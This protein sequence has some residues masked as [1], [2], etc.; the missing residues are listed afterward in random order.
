VRG[1]L[2]APAALSPEVDGWALEP[3]WMLWTIEKSLA[4]AGNRT[5]A[6]QTVT[7]SYID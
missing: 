5:S 3:I 2:R 1:Q 6:V 7:H 4:L